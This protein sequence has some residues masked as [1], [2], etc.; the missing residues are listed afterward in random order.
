[1]EVSFLRKSLYIMFLAVLLALAACSSEKR[2]ADR[3]L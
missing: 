1:M 2:D 3:G